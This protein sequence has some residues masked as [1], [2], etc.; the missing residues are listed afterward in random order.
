[1]V[2]KFIIIGKIN[3]IPLNKVVI[4]VQHFLDFRTAN[5]QRKQQ[6]SKWVDD[7]DQKRK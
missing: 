6:L 5:K 3:A 1:M 2:I 7:D 4:Y